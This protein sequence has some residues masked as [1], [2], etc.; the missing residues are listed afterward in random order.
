MQNKG[1]KSFKNNRTEDKRSSI[2]LKEQILK[3]KRRSIRL[4]IDFWEQNQMPFGLISPVSDQK[5]EDQL[6]SDKTYCN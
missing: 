2:N 3:G 4:E 5:V 1:I 6:K